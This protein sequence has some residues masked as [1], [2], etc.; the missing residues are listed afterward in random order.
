MHAVSRSAS[1]A[2][3]PSVGLRLKASKAEPSPE[4]TLLV[5]LAKLLQGSSSTQGHTPSLLVRYVLRLVVGAGRKPPVLASV[6]VHIQNPAAVDQFYTSTNIAAGVNSQGGLFFRV[7][8]L[9]C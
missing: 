5:I 9:Y 7:V 4:G 3:L 6:Q 1:A 8:E 2:M